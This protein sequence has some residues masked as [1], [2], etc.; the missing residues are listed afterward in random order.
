MI[1]FSE[2]CLGYSFPGHPESAERVKRTYEHL[3]RKGYQFNE[4]KPCE[5]DD[6][7]LIHTPEHLKRVQSNNFFD[8]DTPNQENI[9]EYAA[10]SMG[11]ALQAL[12]KAL[13]GESSFSLLRPPGH[14]A[15]RDYLG[16]FCYFNN[17]AVAIAKALK[18]V[19]RVAIIDFDGHHGNG[20]EDIFFQEKKVLYLSLHQYPAYPGTGMES[21]GNSLNFPLPPGAGEKEFM[22]F[23][24]KGLDKV[25]QF[26]PS[27]IAVSAGFDAHKRETLLSLSLETESYFKIG[28]R[29]K[30]LEK[31][32]FAILE[33]GYHEDLPF[34][35]ENFLE[36]AG[37]R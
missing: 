3:S 25:K 33:G 9:Y 20:T 1:F 12:T 4:A 5:E 36:G 14:H 34:C 10:L 11:G 13:A 19:D 27:L 37:I 17:I 6:I 15:G 2:R 16:G 23:F 30:G 29:I 18:K 8:P 24:L 28:E 7:L 21:R 35:L 32:V 31:P 26:S 22:S